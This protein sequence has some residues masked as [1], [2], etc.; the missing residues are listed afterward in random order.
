MTSTDFNRSV[1]LNAQIAQLLSDWWTR[2]EPVR[3]TLWAS[4]PYQQQVIQLWHATS[5]EG[6]ESVRKL[7]AA[8]VSNRDGL[9]TEY[10]RL[11][12][13]PAA[14]PCPPYEAVWRSDRPKHEQGTVM[15]GSTARIKQIY[16][17]LSVRLRLGEVELPDHIAIELEA[18]AHALRTNHLAQ[19]DALIGQFQGWLPA[20]AASVVANSR[21]EFYRRLA[22]LT[23]EFFL[24]LSP[25]QVPDKGNGCR[26]PDVEAFT[27]SA[28]GVG[29]CSEN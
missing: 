29:L 1:Q 9:T 6:A 22:E 18:L 7:L 27:D 23:W 11:F 14:I 12:V 28:K 26:A 8:A 3:I 25:P 13:G 2:P 5:R 20:F 4:A 15:G 16:A 10:E 19:A 24:N 17:E 21:L